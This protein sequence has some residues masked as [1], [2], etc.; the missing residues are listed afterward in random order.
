[1]SYILYNNYVNIESFPCSYAMIFLFTVAQMFK[2]RFLKLI[3][4]C[5]FLAFLPE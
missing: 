1:M 5:V 3:L 2:T 4:I